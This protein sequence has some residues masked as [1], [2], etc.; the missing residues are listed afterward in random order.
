MEGLER[1]GET[2]DMILLS[3]NTILLNLEV[4]SVENNATVLHI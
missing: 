4:P 3:K 2:G 1:G